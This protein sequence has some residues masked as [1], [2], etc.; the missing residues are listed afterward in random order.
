MQH[1]TCNIGYAICD[2]QLATL[3]FIH[4][5]YIAAVRLS[6]VH[7]S[8]NV[9]G[10]HDQN[11]TEIYQNMHTQHRFCVTFRFSVHT[12]PKL[13]GNWILWSA[14]KFKPTSTKRVQKSPGGNR[15]CSFPVISVL[16][17]EHFQL[18]FRSPFQL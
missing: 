14:G 15:M 6:L 11:L 9:V 2:M 7:T 10:F 3:L 5:S 13:D 16:K 18:A 1:T 4:L 17:V 12:D 8:K